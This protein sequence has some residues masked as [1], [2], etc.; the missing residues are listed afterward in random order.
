[1]TVKDLID[2]LRQCEDVT[3][4]LTIKVWVRT[5]PRDYVTGKVCAIVDVTESRGQIVIDAE[6]V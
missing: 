5:E 1:M 3:L 6:E 2:V 4:P